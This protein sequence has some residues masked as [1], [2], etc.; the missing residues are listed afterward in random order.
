MSE[1]RSKGLE[2]RES[3]GREMLTPELQGRVN[4]PRGNITILNVKDAEGQDSGLNMYGISLSDLLKSLNLTD[5]SPDGKGIIS[6]LRSG[7]FAGFIKNL[8]LAGSLALGTA[9]CNTDY[10][11]NRGSYSAQYGTQTSALTSYDQVLNVDTLKAQPIPWATKATT[12]SNF[13]EIDGVRYLMVVDGATYDVKYVEC[14]QLTKLFDCIVNG[15]PKKVQGVNDG[16]EPFVTDSPAMW[17]DSSGKQRFSIGGTDNFGGGNTYQG[18]INKNATGDLE[19]SGMMPLNPGFGLGSFFVVDGVPSLLGAQGLMNLNTGT[20]DKVNQKGILDGGPATFDGE[21]AIGSKTQTLMN[22]TDQYKLVASKGTT[23]IQAIEALSTNPTFLTTLNNLGSRLIEP[24]LM[25]DG[26]NGS[27]LVFSM[28]EPGKEILWIVPIPA[29]KPPVDTDVVG[30]DT[31]V[32]SDAGSTGVDTTA[33]GVTDDAGM[34]ADQDAVIPT[35]EVASQVDAVIEID[36]ADIEE[37][38]PDIAAQDVPPELPTPDVGPDT[39]TNGSTDAADAQITPDTSKPDTKDTAPDTTEVTPTLTG[40]EVTVGDCKLE[41]TPITQGGKDGFS[42]DINGSGAN[43]ALCKFKGVSNGKPVEITLS[44]DASGDIQI[45][46]ITFDG[47]ELNCELGLDTTAELL[48]DKAG[49]KI[50]ANGITLGSAASHFFTTSRPNG[51]VDIK[52]AKGEPIVTVDGPN[53]T[54]TVPGDG[55]VY[56]IDSKTGGMEEKF[57]DFPNADAGTS[58]DIQPQHFDASGSDASVSTP[59]PGKGGGCEAGPGSVNSSAA[60]LAAVAGAAILFFRRKRE[61]ERK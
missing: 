26:P 34:P 17:K 27:V 47:S 56:R 7:K 61:A 43:N 30:G 10:N 25:S 57:P 36:A 5:S 41:P 39:D 53:F 40:F 4:S 50:K 46:C 15:T 37:I 48:E 2:G 11:Y 32:D 23:A 29:V 51:F 20:T 58:I 24:R 35:D 42:V 44:N 12:T 21:S 6:G 59:P 14:D 31:A 45:T 3:V 9:A 28:G 38:T 60:M 18:D 16:N 22:G 13:A 49:A 54:F 55:I 8:S 52:N 19:A 1:I 33:D